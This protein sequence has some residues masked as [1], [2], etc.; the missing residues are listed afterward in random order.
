MNIVP[1]RQLYLTAISILLVVLLLLVFIIIST[2][3]NLNRERNAAKHTVHRQALTLIKALEAGARAGMMMQKTGADAIGNLVH[4]IGRSDDINYLYLVDADGN[5]VHHSIPS[6]KGTRALWRPPFERWD[7]VH[8]RIRRLS[9]AASVYEVAKPFN[10]MG[11]QAQIT[12]P[13]GKNPQDGT[14][15]QFHAHATV[16]LGMNMAAYETARRSDLQHALIMGGIVLVLGGGVIYFFI[17]LRGYYMLNR[18]LQETRDHTRQ[19]IASMAYGVLSIDTDGRVVSYN[20]QALCLLDIAETDIDHIDLHKIFDFKATGIAKTL[21]PGA[22]VLSHEIRFQKPSGDTIPLMLTATPIKDETGGRKGAVIVI[23]DMSTI[24]ALE[25]QVRRTERL[26]AVGRLAAGVAH[27]IRNP[28]SSIRGFAYLLGKD[29]DETSSK[30]EYADVMVREIDRINHVVSNL[31]DFARPMTLE[32]E[33]ICIDDIIAH[34]VSL[35]SADTKAQNIVIH[36]H[37]GTDCLRMFADPNQLT[38]AILNLILNAIQALEGG[39]AIDIRAGHHDQKQG[40][41]LH[42]EDN[43]PG[44]EPALQEKI[45]EPFYT[46]REKGTGLGLAMVRKIAESHNGDVYFESPP[47]GKTSGTRFTLLLKDVDR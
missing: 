15:I 13:P 4:E 28:L 42:V 36:I 9:D 23:R 21:D 44:I 7:D 18:T 12:T 17:V 24:K 31:L 1:R 10:P 35:V 30:H 11:T 37:D 40:V 33:D 46:S 25:E 39:G 6:L 20:H 45:F 41:I 26:A 2:V 14:P 47:P 5:V 34:V 32:P 43:G 29:Y 3:H 16:Y 19:V 27:E 38:Q 8:T 22:S